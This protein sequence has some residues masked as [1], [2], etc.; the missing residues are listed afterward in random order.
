MA[1]FQKW[2][3]P[4]YALLAAALFGVSPTLAKSIIGES[5]PVL[6]AGLLYVGSGLGLSLFMSISSSGSFR[7]LGSLS[8]RKRMKLAGATLSGGILA[9]LCLV[10]GIRL[11]SAFEV[12]LL[13]NLESVTTTV[14]AWWIFREHVGKPV[15]AG[16]V[17]LILGGIAISYHPG[18]PVAFSLSGWLVFLACVFWGI[19]NNLTRDVDELSPS[20]LAATKGWVA[21]SFNVALALVLGAGSSMSGLHVLET[22]SIGAFSYGM[23][24]VLFI[25]ALRKLGSSRTSTYFAIGPFFGMFFALLLLSERPSHFQW[26]AAAIMGFGLWILSHESH[27]HE[28]T[29]EVLTHRHRHLHD[30][31]HQHLHSGGEGEEPHDHVHT[32]T[33][34]THHHPH[35]PDVHHRHGHFK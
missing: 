2:T 6:L 16:K 14:I 20:V 29:H 9:P 5:S 34:L 7:E 33:E 19:D 32:H 35:W 24:L 25:L 8:F 4:G 12:S 30:E 3:A 22:L 11:G 23:S 1:N 27:E 13:L 15:W 10:Y 28:H 21:G 31:H 26:V 18:S 17:L